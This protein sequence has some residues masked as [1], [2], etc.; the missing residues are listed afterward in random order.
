MIPVANL[1]SKH[2]QWKKALL[3]YYDIEFSGNIRSEFGKDC[4][5]FEIALSC[6]REEFFCVINPYLTKTN[7]QP[8][9]HPKYKM[10]SKEEY[11]KNTDARS[12]NIR[13]PGVGQPS[14]T[15]RKTQEEA[16][17]QVNA[18]IARDP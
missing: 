2:S 16:E 10:L 14:K 8:T 18:K 17:T 1:H 3:V 7:V 4:S 12:E 6:K 15:A 9:V 11:S 5:I 13:S